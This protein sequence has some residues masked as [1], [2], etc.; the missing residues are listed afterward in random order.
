[1]ETQK[2]GTHKTYITRADRREGWNSYLDDYTYIFLI[3]FLIQNVNFTTEI[4]KR[5]TELQLFLNLVIPLLSFTIILQN[6]QYIN[7]WQNPKAIL[8]DNKKQLLYIS[9]KSIC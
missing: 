3:D 5:R 8:V 9:D 6:I 1:M 7:K 2:C 4:L